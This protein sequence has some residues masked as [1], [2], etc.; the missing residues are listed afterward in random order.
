MC[1]IIDAGQLHS[2]VPVVRDLVESRNAGVLVISC[3]FISGTDQRRSA[4]TVQCF[5]PGPQNPSSTVQDV[6]VKESDLQTR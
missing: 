5:Q 4:D 6:V 3:N 2:H 1:P